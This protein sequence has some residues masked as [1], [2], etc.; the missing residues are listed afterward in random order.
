[1]TSQSL[2]NRSRLAWA[3]AG[4]ALV[5]VALAAP[6]VITAAQEQGKGFRVLAELKVPGVEPEISGIYPHPTNENLYYV[7]ANK[8]PSYRPGQAPMLPE[9]YRGK[10]LTVDGRTGE[11]VASLD[12]VNG[13]YGD[14]AFGEG[15]LFVSSLEPAE[16]VKVNLADGKVVAR[17]PIAGPAGGLEYDRDRQQLVA[18]L[19]VGHPHL[20]VIDPK[21]GATVDTL[22][23]DESAMGLAK[24][25]GDLLCTWASGFDEHAFSEMRLLDSKTGKVKGRAP[26]YGG[27]HTALAPVNDNAFLSLV[28]V[29]RASGKVMVRKYA[30]DGQQVAWRM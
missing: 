7:A 29:D 24:V 18:Q 30:Y 10:L 9:Q 12:L 4:L 16:I 11:V 27:I 1:M 23:S 2:P 13:D 6:S 28:A 25:N 19:F 15:H 8:R 5:L 22:W 20:A 26:L 17:F 21:T 3:L 14:L